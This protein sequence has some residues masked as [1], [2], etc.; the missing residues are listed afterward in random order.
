MRYSSGTFEQDNFNVWSPSTVYKVPLGEKW[1]A[2]AEYFGVFT[3]GRE[4]ESKQHF[5]SPSI[6]YLVTRNLEVGVRVGWGL[7]EQS[8]NFFS[9]VGVGLRF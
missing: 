8:P 1:K 7:N 6:H 5:F 4:K 9:N 2:H 3:E